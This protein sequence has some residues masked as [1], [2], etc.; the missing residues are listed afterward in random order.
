MAFLRDSDNDE[1]CDDGAWDEAYETKLE[2][3]G[4]DGKYSLHE[5]WA[6]AERDNEWYDDDWYGDSWEE[7]DNHEYAT[8]RADNE[9][10]DEWYKW[11]RENGKC[12]K[13]GG[14]HF[15]S[16]C[17]ENDSNNDYDGTDYD[18]HNSNYVRPT[19]TQR[20]AK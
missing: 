20:F 12:Y 5:E 2:Y 4:Y 18:N 3:D 16:E 11:C 17:P 8:K 13:C 1:C 15:A 10:D 6:P 7:D 9:Y 19:R 14:D